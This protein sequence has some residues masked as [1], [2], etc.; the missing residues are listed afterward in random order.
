VWR[1]REFQIRGAEKQKVQD[2]NDRNK[3]LIRRVRLQTEWDD[4]VARG[5]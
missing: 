1:G 4:D 3:Q 2:P 5:Q